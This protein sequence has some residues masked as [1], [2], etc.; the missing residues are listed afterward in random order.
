MNS[1]FQIIA[2]DSKYKQAFYDLNAHWIEK[3]FAMEP[4]DIKVLSDPKTY[5]ID[6]GGEVFFALEGDMIL[7]TV[8]LKNDGGGIYELTKLGVDPKIHRGGAGTA[9]CKKVIEAYQAKEDKTI[10]YLESNSIL[11]DAR[12]IYDRLGFI[13]KPLSADTPYARADYYM[14]WQGY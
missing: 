9:L 4:I 1:N 14:E 12:R 2:Y 3:Y 7:G 5:I 8:A 6:Q 13:E 11:T 10:L